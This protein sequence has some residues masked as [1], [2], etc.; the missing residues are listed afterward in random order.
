MYQRILVP[1]DGSPTSRLGLRHAIGLAKP[2]GARL[3]LLNVV[4]ELS[5]IPA[6]D[7]YAVVDLAAMMAAL[8]QGGEELLEQSAGAAAE[9]GVPADKVLVESHGHHV[10]D[11]VVNEAKK[12]G[13]DLICMGTHGRRGISKLLLGSDAERVLHEAPTPV[14][15]VRAVASAG[16]SP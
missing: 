2:L 6:V 9:A 14:L 15:L 4:D 13:A 8:R 11:S 12:W 16:A 1:V 5:L 3:R 10:S 7:A